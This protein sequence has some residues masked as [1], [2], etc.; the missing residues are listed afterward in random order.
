ME[1]ETM[2]TERAIR[3]A[4]KRWERTS[5]LPADWNRGLIDG[6]KDALAWVLDFGSDP[7]QHQGTDS[8]AHASDE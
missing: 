6:W 8:R 4:L 3:R 1:R 2:K 5:R 7:L